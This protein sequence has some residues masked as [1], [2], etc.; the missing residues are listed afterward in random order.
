MNNALTQ[1]QQS[2]INLFQQAMQ[3]PVFRDYWSQVQSNK[4]QPFFN[5][6]GNN[7]IQWMGKVYQDVKKRG[8][9][10][11]LQDLTYPVLMNPYIEPIVEPITSAIRVANY[12]AG[13]PFPFINSLLGQTDSQMAKPL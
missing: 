13:R 5:N 3:N 9:F 12:Q 2:F 11:G 4:Q 1:A 10:E 7:P 8:P 6:T